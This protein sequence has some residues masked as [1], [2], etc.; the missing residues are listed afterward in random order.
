[1]T[2]DPPG[3]DNAS[4]GEQRLDA[5]YAAH[6][7]SVLAYAVR[8]AADEHDAADVLAETFLVAWRRLDDIPSGDQALMWL[9]AVARRVLANQK[10]GERRRQRLAQRLGR[11]LV[12]ALETVAPS[13][14]A[15][16]PIVAAL[17]GLGT[18]D[19]EIV[20]LAAWEELSP[21]QIGAVLG[22]TQIAARSRLHRARKRLRA[23]LD[24][25]A[26]VDEVDQLNI[27]EAV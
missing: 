22:I 24:H 14:P 18:D 20:L 15:A 5:L 19:R 3:A 4:A 27:Q 21:Q 9:Y 12:S 11:E 13:E 17:A 7:R 10:R 8:R 23:L 6:G 16:V 26:D 1:M 2:T 25:P